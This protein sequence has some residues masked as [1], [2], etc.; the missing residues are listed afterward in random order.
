MQ[1]YLNNFK[2]FSDTVIPFQKVNFFVGENSTGKTTVLSVLEFISRTGFLYSPVFNNKYSQFGSFSEIVNQLSKDRTY[3]QIGIQF[4]D[5]YEKEISAKAHLYRYL[6][7]FINSGG[8]P[9]LHS[10]KL[11]Q[12]TKTVVC[13][14]LPHKQVTARVCDSTTT[15]ISF[16]DWIH[17]EDYSTEFVIEQSSRT[18][19]DLM[20]ILDMVNSYLHLD[21]REPFYYSV[22]FPNVFA[23]FNAF[24]PVRAK[25]HRFYE[26]FYQPFSRQGDHI[27]ASL[28]KL[29]KSNRVNAKQKVA[30]LQKFGLDS[31]L[32]DR[33]SLSKYGQGTEGPFSLNVSYGKVVSNLA[34]VGY[35]VSQ[36]LPL[37]VEILNS[38]KSTFSLQQPE[39]HLHPRAQAQFGELLY[40]SA[41]NDNNVFFCETHSNY[42][43]DRFRYLINQNGGEDALS[44]VLFFERDESGNHVTVI[45][46]D[47]DGHFPSD[48]P[49]A[50][51]RFFIEEELKML[52]F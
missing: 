8:N 18:K 38:K 22:V 15:D 50:Y 41:I 44:Q 28:K 5:P 1:L 4:Y 43:I 49:D 31:G 19:P 52:E 40:H 9:I 37:S 48:M 12:G 17:L 30:R 33:I 45:P 42:L 46:I 14:N 13:E 51:T 29:L 47:K 7:T 26:S 3:F 24:S 36:V 11:T 6:E 27:P 39:V 20:Y 21:D 16:Y 23:N 34:N 10:I 32:F 2:G 25:P 35:G